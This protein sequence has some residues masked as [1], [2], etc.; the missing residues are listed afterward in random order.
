MKYITKK[1]IEVE[2]G[3]CGKTFAIWKNDLKKHNFCSRKCSASRYKERVR[4][5]GLSNRGQKRPKT[6]LENLKRGSEHHWWKGG[7][8]FRNKKGYYKKFSIKYVACPK[9]YI[10]MARSDGYVMEH[11]LVMAEYLKRPLT[12][13]EIVHHIDHNPENNVI[14]NLMLFINNSAHKKYESQNK[15]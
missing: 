12:K 11:R 7:V 14:E 9:Q 15:N 1:R 10:S 6:N 5:L 13:T 4:K 8:T 3:A 2:C